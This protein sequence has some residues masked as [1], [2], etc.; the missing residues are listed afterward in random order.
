VYGRGHAYEERRGGTVLDIHVAITKARVR[1]GMLRQHEA[2]VL[3]E[4]RTLVLVTALSAPRLWGYMLEAAL[5]GFS[6]GLARPS[7]GRVSTRLH[8]GFDGAQR[9]VQ[10]RV[11]A[12]IER[13]RPDVGLMALSLESGSP[14][15]AGTLHVLC[16]GPGRA[17]LQRRGNMR[18]LS[19]RDDR[20]EGVLKASPTWC[21]EPLEP[22]DLLF[23]GSLTAFSEE[24]LEQLRAE[25]SGGRLVSPEKLV[26]DL[27]RP[28]AD[29]GIGAAAF[30]FR[31]SKF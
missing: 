17:Y 8:Q 16:L 20:P 26:Q 23:G 11:E 28:A 19:P 1:G 6:E 10:A 2:L 30:A 13:R 18:R 12:L 15:S 9:R 29:G 7:D 3:E 25:F 31:A 22:S 5:S 21:A 27:N 24:A 4:G 14:D